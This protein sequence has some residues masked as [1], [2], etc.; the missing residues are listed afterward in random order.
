MEIGFAVGSVSGPRSSVW[1]VRADPKGDVYVEETGTIDDVKYSLHQSGLCR[2]A[3]T[4]K[5]ARASGLVGDRLIE[6]WK[7]PTPEDAKYP[8]AVRPLLLQFPA[9]HLSTT[10]GLPSM[11]D[12][13]IP[14][15]PAGEAT[16]VEFIFTAQLPAE[17]TGAFEAGGQRKPLVIWRLKQETFA[18]AYHHIPCPDEELLVPAEGGPG[19]DRFFSASDPK[20]TGKPLRLAIKWFS[21]DREVLN[22]SELGGYE[23]PRGSITGVPTITNRKIIVQKLD[24]QVIVTSP[25]PTCAAI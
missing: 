23:V 4:K 13:W 9:N 21:P 15:A 16:V 8:E 14:A 22:I 2:N 24:G 12:Q 3:V 17:V 10:H 19:T 20:K 7:R 18:L 25:L 11:P 6:R 1:L 5:R